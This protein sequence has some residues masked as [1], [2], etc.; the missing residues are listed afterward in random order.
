MVELL[1]ALLV[2]DIVRVEVEVLPFVLTGALFAWI[3]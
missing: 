2:V 3:G 1:E